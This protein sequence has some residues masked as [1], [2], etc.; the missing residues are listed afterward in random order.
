MKNGTPLREAHLQIKM[1]KTPQA[2]STFSVLVE[3]S[4]QAS[5]ML[6]EDLK[7]YQDWFLV[8]TS[9]LSSTTTQIF[10][11]QLLTNSTNMQKDEKIQPLVLLFLAPEPCK[12]LALSI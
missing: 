11:S 7:N 1:Y 10:K 9:C 2:Q 5:M 8:K 4:P 12:H 6:P 3:L